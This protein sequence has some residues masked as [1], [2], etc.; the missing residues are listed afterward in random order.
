MKRKTLLVLSVILGLFPMFT[1]AQIVINEIMQSNIDCIMDEMN[2]F[3]DSWVELYNNSSQSVNLS[4]FKIGLTDDSGKAWRLPSKTLNSHSYALVYCDKEGSGFHTDFRLES[5]KDGE[6]YLYKGDAVIDKLTGIDK[7]PAPNI[8]YGRKT[9][10]SEEWGYQH[11]PTPNTTNCGKT[12]ER[13]LGD[14]IFSAEGR[15][16]TS[17]EAIRLALSLPPGSP[18]GTV[19]KMTSDGS[20]PTMSSQTYTSPI[21]INSTRTIRAKLFCEGYLSP[22]SVTHSY[23]FFNRDITLPVISIVT[24]NNYFYD[25]KLGIYVD[26][27]YNSNKKNYSYDW[28][29]PINI[30]YFAEPEKDSEINQLCETR[31]QGGASRASQL[32]SL[33]VYA[34]KRFGKKRL[35]YEFFP[36]QRPGI[37]DFKSVI[38]RNAGNDFDYLYMRDAVI[39][40]TMAKNIDLDWQAWK[41]SIIYINGVYK[42]ILNISEGSTGDDIYT[43]Y[44]GLEDIDML[45]NWSQLKEGDKENWE[46]FTQFYGEH[47]HTLEEYSKWIDW[48]EFINLMVM[49]LFYN[50]QDFPGNNIVMWRPK[51]AYGRWRFVAKDTDFGLGLYGS[52]A[53]YN[54]IEWLYD[55]NYDGNRN[56]ANHYEHTRL[57]RRMMEDEDFKREFIDRAAIYMGDFM[58]ESGTREVWDPMYEMIKTEY[59]YHRK[60]INQWWPNYTTEL[61]NA[62]TWL[63]NRPNH[64]YNQLSNYYKLGKAIPIIINKNATEQDLSAVETSINNIKLT[65]GSFDGKFFSGRTMNITTSPKN[66]KCVKGWKTTIVSN[67]GTTTTNMTDGD[68]LSLTIPSCSKIIIEAQF[69]IDDGIHIAEQAIPQCTIEG[70]ELKLHNIKNGTQVEVFDIGGRLVFKGRGDGHI[71]TIPTPSK[72]F[73]IVKAGNHTFKVR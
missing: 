71:M 1:D 21:T 20:E 60:L 19:I 11:T 10:G 55:P 27:N 53:D 69:D 40:R 6:L 39:Q 45:E 43:N 57:F 72:G 52:S 46:A 58:N 18:V 63:S 37:N 2:E 65:K 4:N 66:G 9:D 50:N 42:G 36:D 12:C 13:I 67:N 56:W 35:K 70:N 5:S 31:V 64:F 16:T 61:T 33:V 28:R 51:T 32:K 47:G 26:G 30:E 22:R 29:R 44:D 8:S 49:N 17:K 14:P 15:A 25:N 54:S 34:H 3:P 41:P 7:Q 48:E 73:H 24:N 23:I 38:L 68:M 59:P 62:R